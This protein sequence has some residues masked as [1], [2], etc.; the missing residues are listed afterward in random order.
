MALK[1]Y[2][3]RCPYR[4]GSYLYTDD[5]NFNPNE[6]YS[7]T[8]WKQI[9]DKFLLA[10]GDTYESGSTGG[11]TSHTLSISEMPTHSH[12][13]N[14]GTLGTCNYGFGR[15][16][17]GLLQGGAWSDVGVGRGSPQTYNAGSGHAHNN[18]PPYL[19]VYI[20]VRTQ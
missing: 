7:G 14:G 3:G 10:C 5:K 11:E 15:E 16:V 8:I 2:V 19:A 1:T 17:S 13:S 6:T 20:W 9:K 12:G 18:M 4:I